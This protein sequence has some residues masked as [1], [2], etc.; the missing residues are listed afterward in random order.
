[1]AH[2]CGYKSLQVVLN[3]TSSGGTTTADDAS[4]PV[5]PES[6]KSMPK[7][8]DPL[9]PTEDTMVQ[10]VQDVG[11][12]VKVMAQPFPI[13]KSDT[14][15]SFE[16]GVEILKGTDALHDHNGVAMVLTAQAYGKKWNDGNRGE[17]E[18]FGTGTNTDAF[19]ALA[20][21]MVHG[22]TTQK[23]ME[24]QALAI[25]VGNGRDKTEVHAIHA[26][27]L[28][29]FAGVG[30]NVDENKKMVPLYS[31]DY[32]EAFAEYYCMAGGVFTGPRS[33]TS[34]CDNTQNESGAEVE[35]V[36]VDDG[37]VLKCAKLSESPAEIDAKILGKDAEGNDRVWKHADARGWAHHHYECGLTSD[38]LIWFN[39]CFY[40]MPEC[41]LC[42]VTRTY[43]TSLMKLSSTSSDMFSLEMGNNCYSNQEDPIRN[44]S[45]VWKKNAITGKI[46]MC[47]IKLGKSDMDYTLK[48]VSSMQMEK[49]N[50][51]EEPTEPT[52]P[53]EP[54]VKT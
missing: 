44:C 24:N 46:E 17:G 48:N 43:G 50:E 29:V 52:E 39:H 54:K 45:G 14:C 36:V 6:L 21:D 2:V 40:V 5:T 11:C 9:A 15:K 41:S 34:D 18:C 22:C 47:G 27:G 26:R 13:F 38:S 31:A 53:T 25:C 23:I 35:G 51:P 20:E 19:G 30:K 16:N 42:I 8:L 32:F 3:L 33:L 4:G 49:V 1:M 10:D 12:K 28:L 7:L 37:S